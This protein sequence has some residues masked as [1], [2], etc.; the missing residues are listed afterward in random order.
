MY[1]IRL[2]DA[3]EYM[4][5]TNWMRVVELVN[6]FGC[7]PLIGIIPKCEDSRF[8]DRYEYN[9][10]FWD[11]VRSWQEKGFIL[12]LHGFNHVTELSDGGINPIHNRSEF[13]SLSLEEQKK[14]I[15]GGYNIF[16]SQNI[17]AKIF[18]YKKQHILNK[19]LTLAILKKFYKI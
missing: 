19:K 8:I 12:A 11:L 9:S 7:C 1:L 16:Q 2:D 4:D 17:G 5:T 15:R 14:K 6:S 13:V 18:F 10:S 3:S